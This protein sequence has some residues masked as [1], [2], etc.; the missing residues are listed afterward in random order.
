L[1]LQQIIVQNIQSKNFSK[2]G[3]AVDWASCP[4]EIFSKILFWVRTERKFM[5]VSKYIYDMTEED[6]HHLS[7][8]LS[9]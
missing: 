2:I 4:I 6:L 1:F 7:L 3:V 9:N 8:S 5:C